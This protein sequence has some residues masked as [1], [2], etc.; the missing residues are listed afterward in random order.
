MFPVLYLWYDLNITRNFQR[1]K[2]TFNIFFVT[3]TYNIEILVYRQIE[4]YF[5]GTMLKYWFSDR[6]RHVYSSNIGLYGPNYLKQRTLPT[7]EI[8]S[9]R[10]EG[11]W[12][13]M[14][15]Y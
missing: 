4:T 1:N 6:L 15:S 12:V 3:V 9:G 10:N 13:S 7:G 11:A 8:L 2:L 14:V 5:T